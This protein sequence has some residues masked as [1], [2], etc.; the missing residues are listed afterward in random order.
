MMDLHNVYRNPGPN[1]PGFIDLR[2]CSKFE[3]EKRSTF[4][5]NLSHVIPNISTFERTGDCN[6]FKV[7]TMAN[8]AVAVSLLMF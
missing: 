2:L 6:P 1:P 8:Y 5:V 7:L 3:V 4:S